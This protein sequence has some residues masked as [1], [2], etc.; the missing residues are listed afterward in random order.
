MLVRDQ[1]DRLWTHLDVCA[2]WGLIGGGGGCRRRLSPALAVTTVRMPTVKS[3]RVFER[4]RTAQ[5]DV[6]SWRVYVYHW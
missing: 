5:G 1:S 6:E 2:G 3:D 4:D